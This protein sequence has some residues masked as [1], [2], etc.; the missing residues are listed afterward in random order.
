MTSNIYIVLG[1]L[2]ALY[3]LIHMA[4]QAWF[5]PSIKE[6]WLHYIVLLASVI[7]VW[8]LWLVVGFIAYVT[9][10]VPKKDC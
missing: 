7:M 6:H 10:T 1:M 9:E 2:M 4:G 8:P 5:K 3:A